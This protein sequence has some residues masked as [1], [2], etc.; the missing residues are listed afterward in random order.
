MKRNYL[1]CIFIVCLSIVFG[2]KKGS[3]GAEGPARPQG[4]QGPAGTANVIFS[5]W[6]R[7]VRFKDTTM[8]QTIMHVGHI[9]S[10]HLT[11]S[12]QNSALVLMY[13]DF[14]GG[15]FPLP[16]TSNSG[17]RTST[18]NFKLKSNEFVI[19]RITN[20]GGSKINLGTT[21][22]YRYIIIPGGLAAKL[23]NKNI[24]LNNYSEVE[25]TLK[26]LKL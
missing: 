7:A 10:R 3:D 6:E 14:G 18:I 2:C 15:V 20:D 16:L 26:E 19:Y 25:K 12:V 11:A 23:K 9:Y 21:I 17:G 4:P 1:V 22:S 5:N 24:D 8:D 13:M